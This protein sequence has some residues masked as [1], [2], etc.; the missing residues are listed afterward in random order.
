MGKNVKIPH[1][2]HQIHVALWYCQ[3][4]TQYYTALP[5]PPRVVLG[6]HGALGICKSLVCTKNRGPLCAIQ[7]FVFCSNL[8]CERAPARG[9]KRLFDHIYVRSWTEK[10]LNCDF[11]QLGPWRSGKQF[12]IDIE[13]T[14][15]YHSEARK[16]NFQ[17]FR[18][19]SLC[20]RTEMYF[21]NG[22]QIQLRKNWPIKITF[23]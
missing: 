9:A 6:D 14:S 1:F 22:L 23:K 7:S 17:H 11:L 2:T 5:L 8:V 12:W 21:F 13:E 18:G 20:E 10:V 4:P 15:D 16:T 3:Y 19:K